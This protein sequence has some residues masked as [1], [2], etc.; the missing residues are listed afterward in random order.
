MDIVRVSSI[1]YRVS[2]LTT[3]PNQS[4]DPTIPIPTLARRELHISQLDPFGSVARYAERE[5]REEGE[6]P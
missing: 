3:Y 2:R 1:E 6:H 5:R 4:I